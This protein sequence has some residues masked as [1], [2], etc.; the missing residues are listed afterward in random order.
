[1]K[2]DRTLDLTRTDLVKGAECVEDWQWV[3][4]KESGRDDGYPDVVVKDWGDGATCEGQRLYP[5]KV[6]VCGTLI[7]LHV[8][9]PKG[10]SGSAPHPRRQRDTMIEFS[11]S[12]S[13]GSYIGW[14]PAHPHQRLYMFVSP[15]ARPALQRRFWDQNAIAPRSL[16]HVASLAGGRHGR[17]GDYAPC[18][19]KPIGV[20]TAVVY[21]VRKRGDE[22]PGDPKSYYIHRMG[23]LSHHFPI[24]CIDREGRLFLAGGNYTVP[25]QGITD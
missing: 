25:T 11:R 4:D 12:V 9:A 1:M 6:C 19:V 13:M 23:E 18:A 16:P 2:V 3:P 22:N 7:R 15:G 24:L 5:K 17:R 20:L 21:R 10:C 8:R 14:D